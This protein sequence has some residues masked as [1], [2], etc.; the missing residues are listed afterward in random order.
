MGADCLF[1]KIVNRQ[2]AADI[3]FE[4]DEVVA[5]NDINPQAPTHLL[6]IP[7]KHIATVNDLTD[8]EI[9]LPGK[10]I[11]RAKTIASERGIADTGYRLIMNCNEQGGQTVFHIHLHLL[12]GRQLTHLG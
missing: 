9:D 6:I 8:A 12:G 4:D 5:F 11:L 2:L 1:C 7:K 3:V 10:L